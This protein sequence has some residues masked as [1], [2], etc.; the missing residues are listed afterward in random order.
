MSGST[1][2]LEPVVPGKAAVA[3]RPGLPITLAVPPVRVNCHLSRPLTASQELDGRLGRRFH[4]I[5]GES[6]EGPDP[7]LYRC[8][9]PPRG[10]SMV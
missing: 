7:A 9:I 8:P 5:W 2:R 1:A 3:G 4:C 10:G 6:A